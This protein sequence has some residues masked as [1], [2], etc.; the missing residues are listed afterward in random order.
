MVDDDI[1]TYQGK[2][3]LSDQPNTAVP[4]LISKERMQKLELLIHLTS[5]LSQPLA[6]CG[7]EGIGKTTLLKVF[8]ERKVES[9]L[10]CSVP[11]SADL[12][13]EAIQGQL[14]QVIKRD[15][16]DT[17]ASSLSMAFE[18][19]ENQ[20]KQIVLIIDNAGELMPGLITM[21][22][23]YAA[24]NPVLRV[25]FALTHDEL[26]VKQGSDRAVD[27]CHIV[28]IPYLS[29]KQCG[30]FL[31]QLAAKPAA[32]GSVK[33]SAPANAPY[34]HPVGKAISESM[35][36]NIYQKT[37]G[38]PGRIV[39]ESARLFGA[40]KSGKLKWILIAALV[41][42]I[43]IALGVQWLVS[44][45]NNQTTPAAVEQKVDNVEIA[46]SQPEPHVAF[47]LPPPVQP[48][49]NPPEQSVQINED[50]P[51]DI[52]DEEDLEPSG[53]ISAATET[54]TKPEA[55]PAVIDEKP[56]NKKFG[57]T[58]TTTQSVINPPEQSTQAKEE[59]LAKDKA[60]AASESSAEAN[61]HKDDQA[62]A[63]AIKSEAPP[64]PSPHPV[65][66]AENAAVMGQ[67]QESKEEAD[68]VLPL[69]AEPLPN[70][71]TAKQPE[72]KAVNEAVTPAPVKAKKIEAPKK[73]KKPAAAPKE[74]TVKKEVPEEDGTGWL[75]TQPLE[76]YT[77]QL[78]VSSKQPSLKDIRKK[79]PLLGQG[80]RVIKKVVDGKETF[81]LLYGSF[82]SAK[83]A[84]TV[85]QSLSADFR[86]AS[87]RK[88]SS[89]KQ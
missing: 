88:I 2:Q 27:D 65:G 46:P 33:A 42:S 82:N 29:A 3:P 52:E 31:Q 6:L 75:L 47:E 30:E 21:I 87:A 57:A 37:N 61:A 9:W 60:Q 56:E 11:G 68:S 44:S 35:I 28:E 89:L 16:T 36:E 18:Q 20:H 34:L 62:A 76:N 38:I 23:R 72:N 4:S 12:S 14:A 1:F 49:T 15:K 83:V 41:I 40:K 43:A 73:Q 26:Q 13:F 19:Y 25:I 79:Y 70:Q 5:N 55:A 32:N 69:V 84:N 51:A 64:A 85:K 48:V 80:F 8:Q 24:A 63:P 86:N 17:P 66:E 67:K 39:A 7:P 59:V 22:I 45:R 58:A 77:L 53:E 54:K 71:E 10:Y 50:I 81:I 78:M 74:K